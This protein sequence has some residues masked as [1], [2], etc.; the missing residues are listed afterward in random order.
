MATANPTA[1]L[2]PNTLYLAFDR[3]VCNSVHCAGSSALFTGRTI[4]GARVTRAT[5]ADVAE[6]ESLDLGPMRCECGAITL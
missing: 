3:Y 2:K 6:W 4:G 1:V 5:A